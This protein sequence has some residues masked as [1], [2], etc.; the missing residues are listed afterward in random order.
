[1][2]SLK[3][4]LKIRGPI[5]VNLICLLRTPT[6]RSFGQTPLASSEGFLGSFTPGLVKDIT[7]ESFLLILFS[8][9][10]CI[11]HNG[12]QSIRGR[13]R[14][15]RTSLINSIGVS[16]GSAKNGST[17]EVEEHNEREIEIRKDLMTPVCSISSPG[18]LAPLK[19]T[20]EALEEG[21]NTKK[22]WFKK[23]GFGTPPNVP[24][25]SCFELYTK[26][27]YQPVEESS[28]EFSLTEWL[29]TTQ[30]LDTAAGVSPGRNNV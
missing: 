7:E 21:R 16:P 17:A 27:K 19:P 6:F 5:R 29:N 22:V 26:T 10:C 20:D 3:R 11:L 23:Q 14:S 24:K 1:M 4:I 12:R 15:C 18:I 8:R 28:I 2:F 30:Q 13:P 9:F 25:I